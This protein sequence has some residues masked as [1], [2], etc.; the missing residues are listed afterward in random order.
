MIPS[1]KMKKI[2]LMLMTLF[3]FNIYCD[4]QTKMI[5]E[6]RKDVGLKKSFDAKIIAQQSHLLQFDSILVD[7]LKFNNLLKNYGLYEDFK[8]G[9]WD[10]IDKEKFQQCLE[11][12]KLLVNEEVINKMQ[13]ERKS[14]GY[15][16]Q[17]IKMIENINGV[18]ETK[19]SDP[20]VSPPPPP[21]PPSDEVIEPPKGKLI[22]V[23]NDTMQ[24]GF[25]YIVDLTLSKN[26]TNQQVINIIDGFKN[27]ELIDT[28]INITTEMRAR[29]LDPSG[30]NFTITPITSEKQNTTNKDLLR[31]QWQII[32]LV[33]GDNF[34]T[35]SVDNYI[36]EQPQSVNIYNGKK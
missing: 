35:I 25:T 6:T 20:T 28:L 26:M 2:S 1:G 7:T 15:S 32:P 29:L 27:K 13:R 11:L 21:P 23:I 31:W 18:I 5:K 14:I 12:S 3:F 17:E 30:K 24:V 16:A 10:K 19:N 33:E 4:S 22:Y 34:L 8:N 9:N 36:D